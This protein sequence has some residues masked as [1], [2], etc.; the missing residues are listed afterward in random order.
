MDRVH[1]TVCL[2]AYLSITRQLPKLVFLAVIPISTQTT[3][4][5]LAR[6]VIQLAQRVVH[7]LQTA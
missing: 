7:P 5:L 3:R 6:T 4:L 1:Q 2:V